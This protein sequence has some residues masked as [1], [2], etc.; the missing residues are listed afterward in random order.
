MNNNPSLQCSNGLLRGAEN[1]SDLLPLVE[2]EWRRERQ[3]LNFY[4]PVFPSFRASVGD[5]VIVDNVGWMQQRSVS[6]KLPD[7]TKLRRKINKF[8]RASEHLAS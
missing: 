4:F 8:V 7:T 6:H 1:Y 5:L 2:R 3:A